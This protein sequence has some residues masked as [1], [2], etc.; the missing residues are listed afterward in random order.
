[1]RRRSW[2]GRIDTGKEEEP[3]DPAVQRTAA[4]N[5]AIGLLARREHAQ[6]EIKRKLRDRGY[7]KDLTLEVVDD[8]TRQRLLSD[9][10][11]AEAFIRSRADR[12]QGPVRLRAELRQLQIP[13]EQIERQLLAVEVDWTALARQVRLRKF[14]KQPPA[15]LGERAKQVRFLQYRGFMAGQIRA[16]LGSSCEDELLEAGDD[17]S[18]PPDFDSE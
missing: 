16:A 17:D 9:T 15:S 4:R 14:G 13:A 3:A 10:R 6:A 12:G 7:D 11:F 2:S 8:L 18:D 5:T 1:M